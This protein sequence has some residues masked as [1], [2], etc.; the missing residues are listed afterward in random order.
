MTPPPQ[1][2]QLRL[3]RA[4]V[5]ALIATDPTFSTTLSSQ[6]IDHVV[7]QHF[8]KG[9]T[10]NPVIQAHIAAI[11]TSVQA[12]AP[13]IMREA[14]AGIFREGKDRYSQVTYELTPETKAQLSDRITVLIAQQVE[15]LVINELAKLEAVLTRK[16]DYYVEHA[17]TEKLRK[18]ISTK[19]D[20]MSK[21]IPFPKA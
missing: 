21:A 16:V 12:Q 8:I 18:A 13:T 9:I 10:D 3:N 2:V 15:T 4:A 19:L 1:H 11:R 6:L 14:A 17:V 5:D 20:E 7:R